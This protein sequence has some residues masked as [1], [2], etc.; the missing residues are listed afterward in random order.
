MYNRYFVPYRGNKKCMNEE[1]FSN[2]QTPGSMKMT[3][4][5]GSGS[6]AGG[7]E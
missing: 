5:L 6:R 3:S 1:I 7:T 2:V 4:L